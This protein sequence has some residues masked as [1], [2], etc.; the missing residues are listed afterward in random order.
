[1][2]THPLIAQD[3]PWLAPLAGYSD[4]SFRL[5]CRSLGADV[6]VTEMISSKGLI[7][8]SPGTQPILKTVAA[9]NPLV[10]QLFGPDAE[11]MAKATVILRQMGFDYFDLNSGCPVRKV[12]KTGSGS[13]LHK[14]P[15]RLVEL[16]RA[17]VDNAEPGK[18]GVKMRLGWTHDDENYLD[19]AK[20]LEDIGV[21]W[22]TLHP[23][24]AKQAFSGEA[25][26][27]KL[28]A[29]KETV[30]IPI[31]ASGDLYTAHHAVECVRQTN[32]D[33]VMFA[34]GALANP[35]I[36]DEYKALLRRRGN[37]APDG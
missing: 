32:V 18:V 24:T 12:V 9:D 23:R 20:E 11:D 29:L 14:K 36:F 34:R 8:N 3:K 10:A 28:T 19:I 33:G 15:A 17:I 30:S 35:A 5:L 16:A 1:M 22:I 26:W 31:I 7:Y 6:C 37:P 2:K 21:A 13:A 4:L 25:N 27:E